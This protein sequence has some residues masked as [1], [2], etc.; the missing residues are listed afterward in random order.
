MNFNIQVRIQEII[1]SIDKVIRINRLGEEKYQKALLKKLPEINLNRKVLEKAKLIKESLISEYQNELT[2]LEIKNDILNNYK[3][4]SDFYHRSKLVMPFFFDESFMK[5]IVEVD[6]FF[7][8]GLL[9]IIII[10]QGINWRNSFNKLALHA[11][12]HSNIVSFNMFVQYLSN[13]IPVYNELKDDDLVSLPEIPNRYSRKKLDE[14][15]KID[16]ERN[17]LLNSLEKN[18]YFDIIKNYELNDKE[19]ALS[20]LLNS[21]ETIEKLPQFQDDL[22]CCLFAIYNNGHAIKYIGEAFKDNEAIVDIAIRI[23]SLKQRD[24]NTQSNFDYKS[25]YPYVSK[26]MKQDEILAS[27]VSKKD[28]MLLQ[29]MSDELK[30]NF[31]IVKSCVNNNGLAIQFASTELRSNKELIDEAIKQ[32]PAAVNHVAPENR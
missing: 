8:E 30:N 4:N 12:N 11:I 3:T 14:I 15:L 5:K 13:D 1:E 20:A 22:L 26:R 32:N 25:V 29:H 24:G 10:D 6:P 23:N 21:W 9:K 7:L 18:G 2:E 19:I 31:E 17:L 27:R 28:G 16:Y